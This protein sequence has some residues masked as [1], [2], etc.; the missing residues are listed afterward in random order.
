[1]LSRSQCFI[2]LL[3]VL[4]QFNHIVDF[5]IVMP[6]GPLL[7]PLFGIS[8]S[9]FGLLVSAYTFA[10]GTVG[11]V[12]A[13]FLDRFDRKKALLFFFSGFCLGTFMCA[14]APDYHWLLAARLLTG[15][16]GGVLSSLG[17]A[18]VA[19]VVPAERRGTAMGLLGTS[20]ALASVAGVPFSLTL[21]NQMGWHAPFVF[22]GALSLVI[23]PLIVG[24]LPRMDHHLRS[25]EPRELFSVFRKAVML[26]ERR[27][28]IL[29]MMTLITSHFLLIPFF[30][31]TL[32]ANVG[33]EPE[34]LPMV[35]LVGGLTS[36]ITGPVI[37]FLS[38]RYGKRRV[39][40]LA[41]VN[42]MLALYLVSVLGVWAM[43]WLYLIVV[44]FFLSIGAR[45]GPAMAMSSCLVTSKDRGGYMSLVSSTQQF[46]AGF[47]S[48]FA[49]L[50]VNSVDGRIL[51]Y[52]RV[53][54]FA[55]A[56]TT[57]CWLLVYRLRPVEGKI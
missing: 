34:R 21:A 22:L 36:F 8:P 56:A 25:P 27:D 13:L 55:I 52:D 48:L 6:L 31:P 50:L 45:M 39:F 20:F 29:F 42:S 49:G 23:V 19:D 53:G 9:Q 32:V 16:F 3:L 17:Y 35:Y 44:Y 7:M 28:G 33:L 47:A 12:S 11:L 4:I 54:W 38:D 57:L 46:G 51:G 26:S 14:L 30:S 37:G 2:I 10:A 18:I 43:P 1:M 5:M 41:A 15:M 24:F 40:A